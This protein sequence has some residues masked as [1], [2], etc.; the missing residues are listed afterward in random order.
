LAAAHGPADAPGPGALRA[1]PAPAVRPGPGGGGRPPRGVLPGPLR[2]ARPLSPGPAP[3]AAVRSVRDV[4]ADPVLLDVR[5]ADGDPTRGAAAAGAAER[6][7]DGVRRRAA[8]LTGTG[9]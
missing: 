2:S 6:R 4:R 9:R 1:R 7:G 8:A 3:A 5:H